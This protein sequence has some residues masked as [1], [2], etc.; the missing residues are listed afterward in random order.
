MSKELKTRIQHKIDTAEKW[1]QSTIVPLEGELIIYSN[2]SKTA[3]TDI[4]ATLP[5]PAFK[6]GN[7]STPVVN[8]PFAT[9]GIVTDGPSVDPENPEITIVPVPGI[10]SGV[11][12]YTGSTIKPSWDTNITESNY[13][14]CSGSLEGTNAGTYTTT[15][16]LKNTETT[17]WSNDSTEPQTV[18]WQIQKATYT[19]Q[20]ANNQLTFESIDSV[21][22]AN[23]QVIVK[24][25][26][27]VDQLMIDYSATTDE[28][29]VTVENST[30]S[31]PDAE[32]FY[33][34]TYDLSCTSFVT[35]STETI[36]FRIYNETNYNDQNISITIN[37]IATTTEDITDFG[38]LSW[39]RIAEI[40][41]SGDIPEEWELG[42]KKK[43]QLNG[44]I[45]DVNVSS[46][47]AYASIIGINQHEKG[48]EQYIADPSKK[49]IDLI[50]FDTADG[51]PLALYDPSN[52]NKQTDSDK[53]W[54]MN[55]WAKTLK[56]GWKYSYMRNQVLGSSS[57]INTQKDSFMRAL[58]QELRENLAP[59]YILTSSEYSSDKDDVVHLESVYDYLKLP[60]LGE[61]T[62]SINDNGD[63]AEFDAY[64]DAE[65]ALT[66]TDFSELRL[67]VARDKDA[68][69]NLS[70]SR[71]PIIYWTRTFSYDSYN[72]A[73]IWRDPAD[74]EGSFYAST[75]SS[76]QNFCL[77]ICPIFRIGNVYGDAVEE[78]YYTNQAAGS[79][80]DPEELIE[81][82][83]WSKAGSSVSGMQLRS[84]II[85]YPKGSGKSI[86]IRGWRGNTNVPKKDPSYNTSAQ[87]VEYDENM[88]V[89]R[90]YTGESI[91]GT[92]NPYYISFNDEGAYISTPNDDFTYFSF[93]DSSY[94]GWTEEAFENCSVNTFVVLIG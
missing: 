10:T 89:L 79:T 32:G 42:D 52:Y 54:T 91:D 78:F 21:A 23:Q 75:T 17:K 71:D 84:N 29:R 43:V 46:M 61:V 60:C 58:P 6:I 81:G 25:M 76:P 34:Y 56:A 62:T 14:T 27:N 94:N 87:Y 57:N 90:S 15:F 39:S 83:L 31:G 82:N 86:T 73:T 69:N 16:T 72:F 2:G 51:K 4:D 85:P 38:S 37:C 9:L 7:G 63:P 70:I 20:V 55:R 24:T 11:M 65:Y 41:E 88:N 77:G 64:N 12:I 44:Y 33:S 1:N 36:S 8:L 49:S 13:Y 30:K 50:L 5:V 68:E 26:A 47:E 28:N 45:R 67:G 3:S 53:Y 18:T 48:P 40:V 80:E 92:Y 22:P 66:Y 19:L 74:A 35:N 93:T 59:M